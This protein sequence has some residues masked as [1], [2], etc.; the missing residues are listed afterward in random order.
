MY[1]YAGL[2]KRAKGRLFEEVVKL[3][4]KK[5]Q[6]VLVPVEGVPS[7]VGEPSRLYLFAEGEKLVLARRLLRKEDK[8]EAARL[9]F[10]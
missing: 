2:R 9:A 7:L 5:R 3:W 6:A 10:V 4:Q 8:E 1:P